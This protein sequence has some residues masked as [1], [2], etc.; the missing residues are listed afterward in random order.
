M[1]FVRSFVETDL[2][3]AAKEAALCN[4]ST[5]RCQTCF[6]T[7][8][9]NFFGFEGSLP[10]EGS[11][12]GN[13]THVWNYEQATAFLFGGLARNMR[14]LEFGYA[15]ADDGRMNFRI[16]L[17]LS[18]ARGFGKAAADGQMGCLMKLYRD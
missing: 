16:N 6:R 1:N 14:E 12:Y 11:C 18:D 7:A 2:P 5:L 4:L 10:R 13:C 17:P 15:T 9:G 3:Q 8:D